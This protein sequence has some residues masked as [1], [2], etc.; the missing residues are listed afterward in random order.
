MRKRDI[1]AN[2]LS[3]SGL[4]LASIY[5]RRLGSARLPILAYHRVLQELPT[6]DYI[7]DPKLISTTTAEFEWQIDFIARHFTPVTLEQVVQA[8]DDKKNLPKDAIVITF[9]DGYDDNYFEAFPVLRD[10]NVPATFFISTGYIDGTS[11]FWYDWLS[12]IIVGKKGSEFVVEALDLHLELPSQISLRRKFYEDVV[13]VL[14][15]VPNALRLAALNEL[16]SRYGDFY[17][18]LGEE[19]RRL[20]RP[21]TSAQVKELANNGMQLGSHTVSHP[22]LARLTD[23]E[24]FEELDASKKKLEHW[25]GRPVSILAYPNGG[26]SDF[27]D[28]VVSVAR[29][30]GYNLAV[31]YVA[32]DNLQTKCSPFSLRRIP[33]DLDVTRPIFKMSLALPGLLD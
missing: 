20:S 23:E 13:G 3:W 18:G 16:E 5:G 31:A 4:S 30:I 10:R 32:G 26:L 12:A 7:F 19:I 11:P 29:G 6:D 33:V 15:S 24:L 27:S 25:S 22:I 21:M 28:R 8:L 2:V 14:K 1:L 17:H 9:D